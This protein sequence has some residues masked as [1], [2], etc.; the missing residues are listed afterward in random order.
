MTCP[1]AAPVPMHAG[2]PPRVHVESAGVGP[3]LV[4][5]HGFALHG[6]LFAPIVPALARRARVHVVDLPGH[7]WSGMVKPFDLDAIVAAVDDA[8]IAADGAPSGHDSSAPRAL[9]ILGWSLGGLVAMHWAA[10]RPAR[11]AKLVLVATSPSFVERPGWPCA[12]SSETLARFGDELAV[13]WRLTLQRFLTL[14]VQGSDD[15]RRALAALRS[16]LFERGDPAPA[17]LRATLAI[18]ERS[19]LRDEA[20]AIAAPARLI[21]GQRDTLVPIGAM[22]ALAA[23]IPHASLREIAGA[24]HAPFLSHPQAFFEALDGVVSQGIRVD[25]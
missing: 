7:G 6:G 1:D 8:V 15:G 22:R 4:L 3:P 24:A 10:T 23:M 13:A 17:A 16:H 19:D 25:D 9:A 5:L 18:L 21:A 12:M 14:Q 20:R 2:I 11:V